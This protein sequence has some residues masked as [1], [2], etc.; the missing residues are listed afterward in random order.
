MPFGNIPSIRA[1]NTKVSDLH[2]YFRR[3]SLFCRKF[4]YLFKKDNVLELDITVNDSSVVTIVKR[5]RELKHDLCD[6]P[7]RHLAS[8]ETLPVLV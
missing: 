5:L 8:L 3:C 1:E 4:I 6:L 2:M 7:L